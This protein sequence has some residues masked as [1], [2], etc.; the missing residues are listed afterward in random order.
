MKPIF[1]KTV[2]RRMVRAILIKGEP[3]FAANDVYGALE[4]TRTDVPIRSLAATEYRVQADFS[5]PGGAKRNREAAVTLGGVKSL[6]Q[7]PKA[8]NSA[9]VFKDLST[10]TWKDL[11]AAPPAKNKPEAESPV[12]EKKPETA[13]PA[14]EKKPGTNDIYKKPARG[15]EGRD[16]LAKRPVR[17][18]RESEADA[19]D[20]LAAVVALAK[21]NNES[22]RLIS[23]ALET[24]AEGR[25]VIYADKKTV[26]EER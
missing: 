18:A 16:A 17:P 21:A 15:A 24:L 8:R 7:H 11:E 2:K 13:P 4:I 22:L 25:I 12:A 19:A 14:A 9:R 5:V 26:K 10:A 20:M 23:K 1:I 3:W 6:S